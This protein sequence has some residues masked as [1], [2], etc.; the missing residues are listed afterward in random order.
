MDR[1]R[2]F[3]TA[4]SRGFSGGEMEILLEELNQNTFEL[5]TGEYTHVLSSC[6]S[7]SVENTRILTP[8]VSV[9]STV[10]KLGSASQVAARPLKF[11]ADQVK[12]WTTRLPSRSNFLTPRWSKTKTAVASLLRVG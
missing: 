1:N 6:K 12:A 3:E 10:A 11:M 7:S 8:E 2:I 9:V 4:R 5:S